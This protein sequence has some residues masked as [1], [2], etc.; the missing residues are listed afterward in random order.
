MPHSTKRLRVHLFFQLKEEFSY[1]FLTKTPF[2]AHLHQSKKLT[3]FKSHK[4]FKPCQG[5]GPGIG[6]RDWLY[7]RFGMQ[8]IAPM[9]SPPL[10]TERNG[11]NF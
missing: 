9:S 1:S 8:A 5:V 11:H 4:N 10:T 6:A 7:T 2:L 3:N